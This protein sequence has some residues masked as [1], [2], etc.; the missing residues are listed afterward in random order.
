MFLQVYNKIKEF[1]T[2]II[3]RHKKPDGDALGSQLGLKRAILATFPTKRVLA[4][5]GMSENLAFLGTLD[6]ACDEDYHDALV[7]V[8]DSGAETLIDDERYKT[9]KF[10]IKIDHHIPQGEYGELVLV[11]NSYESCA[12]IIGDLIRNTPLVLTKDSATAIFLGMVT[13]SGRFRFSSTTSKTFEIASYLM[14]AGIEIDEIYNNLYIDSLENVRLRAE[15]T[16]KFTVL[17]TKVAY[18][19][20]PYS[21]VERLGV[22]T[23]QISRG[24][25]GIMAGIENINIW[26]TF[27]ENEHGEVYVE[28]RSNKANINKVA[29]KYGGGGHLQAS[30]A[31]VK[32]L[33]IVPEIIKDLEKVASGE[34]I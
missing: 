15:M 14:N 16:L 17:P 9:G 7:I 1:D 29:V 33:D 3:H 8:L 31:T 11:D 22:S 12:G 2:I 32:S 26:A 20:T 24:M 30:G 13:D 19:L 34:E 18:L 23:Y 5:G 10:L 25:I 28:L 4:V 6:E 21:E 27:T